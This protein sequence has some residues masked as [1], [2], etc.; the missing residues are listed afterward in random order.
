MEWRPRDEQRGR[1]RPMKRWEEESDGLFMAEKSNGARSLK[2]Q[3]G[4]HHPALNRV[5]LI[6]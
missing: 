5:M 3:T 6:D 1:R 4:G 2:R